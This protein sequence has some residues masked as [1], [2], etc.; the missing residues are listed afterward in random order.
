MAVAV[1][2]HCAPSVSRTCRV[3]VPNGRVWAPAPVIPERAAPA[4][5]DCEADSNESAPV[6]KPT[7]NALWALSTRLSNRKIELSIANMRLRRCGCFSRPV[8]RSSLS[9]PLV[10]V[11]LVGFFLF[12]FVLGW[13]ARSAESCGCG[14]VEKAALHDS[15]GQAV[16]GALP[17]RLQEE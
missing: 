12:A 6:A 3:V 10:S 9:V 16:G 15:S 13:L 1:V 8:I 5:R 17:L 11:L 14:V 2:G 4:W 7:E